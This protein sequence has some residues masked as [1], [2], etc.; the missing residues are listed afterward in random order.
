MNIKEQKTTIMALYIMLILSTILSF[1]PNMLL[2]IGSLTL[3]LVALVAAYIYRA[4]DKDDGLL[5]NHMTYL[6]GTIWIGSTF[7]VI[8]IIIA[9]VWISGESNNAALQDVVEQINSGLALDEALLKSAMAQ[10]IS[11][12][13]QLLLRVTLITIG[14]AMV[15]ILY[16]IASGLSRAV[17]G[18]RMAK[19]KSW[20]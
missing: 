4:K 9:V 6:I 5:A 1:A 15:Y 14:P 18:Y 13:Q 3:F 10:Y 7:L 17:R 12:N 19:P 20:L 2:Q 11:D 8:G 16:R